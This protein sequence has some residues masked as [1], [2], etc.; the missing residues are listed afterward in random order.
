MKKLS[1]NIVGGI[2][3]CAASA[4]SDAAFLYNVHAGGNDAQLLQ[5]TDVGASRFKP[6][7]KLWTSLQC[8]ATLISGTETPDKDLPALILTAGHCVDNN[9]GTNRVIVGQPVLQNWEFIP[10]YFIDKKEELHPVKVNKVVYATMKQYDLAVLQLDA[11]YGDMAIKGI[12]PMKLQRSP[13]PQKQPIELAHIPI[14]GVDMEHRYIRHSACNITDKT[15]ALYE[16][17]FPWLWEPAYSMD[18]TGVVGGSSGSPVVLNEQ[19]NIIGI[20]NT[21]VT[22]GYNGCGL[23]RPCEIVGNHSSIREGASYFIPVNRIIDALTSDGILDTTKLD[24]GAG[25]IFNRRGTWI[26]QSKIGGKAA[27]WDI[28][29]DEKVDYIRFKVGLANDTDCADPDGYGSAE[30]AVDQ[31]LLNLPLPEKEGIYKLCAISKSRD[32]GWLPVEHAAFT[33]HEIDDTPPEEKPTIRVS[34]NEA[35]WII[36]LE[37]TPYE[38]ESLQIKYGPR[39]EIQC[40]DKTGYRLYFGIP[41]LLPKAESPWRVCTYG[42]DIAMNNGPTSQRDITPGKSAKASVSSAD[43]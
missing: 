34:E 24:N 21:T 37:A 39:D 19:A 22:P 17:I 12:L 13:S 25:N 40:D 38:I 7:G 20:V 28:N 30:T 16:G 2:L 42:Q 10:D 41:V 4:S 32:A 36:E 31:P 27:T 9:M 29:L 1:S 14:D 33:L 26:S 5:S 23:G 35:N 11:T 43:M 6:V 15:S 18:C 8:T 3:L